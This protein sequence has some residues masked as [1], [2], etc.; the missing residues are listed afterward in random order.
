MTKLSKG[1]TFDAG[2][3]DH[4]TLHGIEARTREYRFQLSRPVEYGRQP[5]MIV[6]PQSLFDDKEFDAEGFFRAKGDAL[7]RA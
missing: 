7:R 1:D 3:G 2:G 6:V 4:W 5:P